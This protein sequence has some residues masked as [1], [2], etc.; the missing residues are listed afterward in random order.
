MQ[1]SPQSPEKIK[2][3][4]IFLGD[5]GTGKSSIIHKYSKKKFKEAYIETYGNFK[6]YN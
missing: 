6:L 5:K 1:T 3:T 2:K 4:I